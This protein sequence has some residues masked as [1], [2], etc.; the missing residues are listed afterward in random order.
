MNV[1]IKWWLN[2]YIHFISNH[3]LTHIDFH[4]CYIPLHFK[5]L[6]F[7]SH[8]NAHFQVSLTSRLLPSHQVINRTKWCQQHIYMTQPLTEKIMS[9]TYDPDYDWIMSP[10]DPAFD[11]HMT[12]AP[13][14]Q[15]TKNNDNHLMTQTWPWWPRYKQW[16][17]TLESPSPP[18]LPS[19]SSSSRWTKKIYY[20][21]MI[22]SELWWWWSNEFNVMF[23][24]SGMSFTW[25]Y[26]IFHPQ[27]CLALWLSQLEARTDRDSVAEVAINNIIQPHYNFTQT[28][29]QKLIHQVLSL[30]DAAH[31]LAQAGV[32]A[33]LSLLPLLYLCL[34]AS[35]CRWWWWW[36]GDGVC[37]FKVSLSGLAAAQPSTSLR[38]ARSPTPWWPLTRDTWIGC[39]GI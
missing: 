6:H 1:K 21:T 20:L 14:M 38:R 39:K 35:C 31:N 9:P 30:V 8:E 24:L 5:S 7:Q 13:A 26:W 37:V 22:H 19:S 16:S 11:Q 18:T 32:G 29:H 15:H 4:S 25:W 3:P 23:H 2:I 34:T 36:D 10:S 12:D 27:E 28:W 17:W 33:A